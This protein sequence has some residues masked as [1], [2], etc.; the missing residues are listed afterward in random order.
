MRA[1]VLHAAALIV[2]PIALAAQTPPAP[3][4]AW[5]WHID[6]PATNVT[7]RDAPP[8][9]WQF[10][11]MV[12]GMHVTSGPGVVVF[13][14]DSASGRFMVDA[15][16]VLF[17]NSSKDGYGIMFGGRSLGEPAATWS[18]F[19]LSADGRFTVVR[20]SSAGDERLIAWTSADTIRKLGAETVTNQLRVAVETDSVRFL[21]NGRVLSALP[22]TALRPDGQFG[23][24]LDPG[25]NVHVTNV[26]VTRRLLRR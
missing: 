14:T 8:G 20:H 7:G 18:A 25:I 2:F 1:L 3:P 22:R 12:P 17:P 16:I 23:L 4:A 21:V 6:K 19:L 13:P 9:A 24:R 26:D 15:T 11:E 5:R 10:Q